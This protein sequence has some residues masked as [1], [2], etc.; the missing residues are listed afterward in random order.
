MKWWQVPLYLV[1][2]FLLN[3]LVVTLFGGSVVA[4][5]YGLCWLFGLN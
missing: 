4:V 5:L 2:G 3:A 1:G